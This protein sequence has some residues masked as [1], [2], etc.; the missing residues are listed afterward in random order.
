MWLSLN[1]WV[2]RQNLFCTM[3]YNDEMGAGGS[4]VRMFSEDDLS[5]QQESGAHQIL[6]CLVF[7][8]NL[9]NFVTTEKDDVIFIEHLTILLEVFC[10]KLGMIYCAS[11]I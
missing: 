5:D 7:L 4:F 6:Q 9:Y 10:F 1:E 11:V 8:T 2:F 3:S